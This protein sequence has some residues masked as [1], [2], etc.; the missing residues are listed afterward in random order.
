MVAFCKSA[1]KSKLSGGIGETSVGV[2]PVGTIQIL[3]FAEH[4][5]AKQFE[6]LKSRI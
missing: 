3:L 4:P 5:K 2:Q 1:D 6:Q